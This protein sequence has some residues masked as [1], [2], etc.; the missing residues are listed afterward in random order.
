MELHLFCSLA[1]MMINQFGC[2]GA[3]YQENKVESFE[4]RVFAHV[5]NFTPAFAKS[6]LE[7]RMYDLNTRFLSILIN[8]IVKDDAKIWSKLEVERR[9]YSE[10]I[11][12]LKTEYNEEI[13]TVDRLQSEVITL[14]TQTVRLKESV[15]DFKSKYQNML[16]NYMKQTETINELEL[17]LRNTEQTLEQKTQ[18]YVEVEEKNTVLKEKYYRQEITTKITEKRMETCERKLKIFESVRVQAE[19]A[20]EFIEVSL[21]DISRLIYNM[22][23]TFWTKVQNYFTKLEAE[24]KTEVTKVKKT[25][26]G[27]YGKL[28]MEQKEEFE[29]QISYVYKE[30]LEDS[31]T[32]SKLR[33]E[34]NMLQEKL[35]TNKLQIEEYKSTIEVTSEQTA[36]FDIVL[37]VRREE[38]EGLREQIDFYEVLTEL[39]EEE[40][41]KMT[42]E[43]MTMRW[44]DLK[45]WFSQDPPEFIRQRLE[46]ARTLLDN[47]HDPTTRQEAD[48]KSSEVQE[49]L[50]QQMKMEGKDLE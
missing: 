18:E 46:S 24:F 35:A 4:E 38:D 14:E 16:D 45:T 3:N 13:K 47:P 50:D 25:E 30:K 5:A 27:K 2:H 11:E 32:I 7:D 41:S 36:T 48:L 49:S 20:E 44:E 23:S 28:V 40:E 15:E 33:E 39:A 10:A 29:R 22:Q 8:K 12:S 17:K 19:T 9:S 21:R 34:K 31:R 43:K 6:S 26:Y 37:N 1:L 42:A